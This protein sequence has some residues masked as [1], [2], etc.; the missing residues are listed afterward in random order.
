MNVT[1]KPRTPDQL[2]NVSF[3][4]H[5]DLARG[6]AICMAPSEVLQAEMVDMSCFQHWR[7]TAQRL[8]M[9]MISYTAFCDVSAVQWPALLLDF[10]DA[11]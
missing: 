7:S 2:N 5:D 3:K 9:L 8:S 1:L 10:V 11:L 4:Q 6:E